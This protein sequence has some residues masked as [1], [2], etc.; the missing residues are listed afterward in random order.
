M[1]VDL[2]ALKNWAERGGQSTKTTDYSHHSGKDKPKNN[3]NYNGGNNSG[4]RSNKSKT[5]ANE[6]S[7]EAA[8]AP[9]N[10]I[11]L[12]SKA[13]KSGLEEYIPALKN[14]KQKDIEQGYKKYLDEHKTVSGY[15]DLELE[16][17][18]PLFIRY[19]NGEP[20]KLGDTPVLPG[21][22]LRGMFKNTFKILTMSTMRSGEDYIDRHVFYRRIMATNSDYRWAHD[23]YEQY[24]GRLQSD[25]GSKVRPGFLIKVKNNYYI[26]SVT[27]DY[28]ETIYEYEKRPGCYGTVT[29]TKD[30]NIKW[31]GS[32]AFILTGNLGIGKKLFKTIQE[33]EDYK[34][35]CKKRKDKKSLMKM[36]KQM[37]RYIKLEDAHWN[38]RHKVN[39]TEYLMDNNRGGVNLVDTQYMKKTSEVNVK[40]KIPEDISSIAP[41]YYVPDDGQI[42]LFGHGQCFRIPYKNPIGDIVKKSLWEDVIDY[43]DAVFGMSPYFASRVFFEDAWP[44]NKAELMPE[45]NAHPLLQPNPT[46]FQLYLK[47]DIG[48][49]LNN[50]DSENAKIRGYK[51]DW[52]QADGKG[53]YKASKE[54]LAEDNKKAADK[55]LCLPMQP[56]KANTKFTSRIRFKNLLP[57][58]LGAL[59]MALDINAKDKNIAFKLGQGKS[60]GLGSIKLNRHELFVETNDAYTSFLQGNTMVDPCKETDCSEYKALFEKAIPDNMQKD[61]QHIIKELADM[62]DFDNTKLSGWQRETSSMKGYI[63]NN[64][65]FKIHYGFIDRRALPVVQEVVKRAGK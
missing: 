58:E 32:S 40:V 20:F 42:K 33:Y 65:Q 28:K 46:S 10:F 25:E 35:D 51:L 30:S 5:L 21:S 37:V 6:F 36:G 18:T 31:H 45:F 43:T 9:Y 34:A 54:E 41:C 52:H 64:G 57:E 16:N 24:K 4:F 22:S 60:L 56:I 11:S 44:E 3:K 23:L 49:R 47:N 12:P 48:K 26:V 8:T 63:D 13:L 19:E 38:D 59:I 1:A 29:K 61:W 14:A 27:R 53:D 55:Q 62:L 7:T 15:L 50:W 17:L 39:I 2:S